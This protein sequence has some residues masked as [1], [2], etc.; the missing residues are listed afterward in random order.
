MLK[1][2]WIKWKKKEKR[3][4]RKTRARAFKTHLLLA[5]SS[6]SSS[7]LVVVDFGGRSLLLRGGD[8]CIFLCALSLFVYLL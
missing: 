7:S 6:F 5:F 3:K 2:F 4:G 1:N 8:M